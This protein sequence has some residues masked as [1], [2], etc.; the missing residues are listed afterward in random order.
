MPLLFIAKLLYKIGYIDVSE[1][2]DTSKN[3]IEGIKSKSLN[4]NELSSCLRVTN[5][6]KIGYAQSISFSEGA[7]GNAFR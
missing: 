2:L 7:R 3:P 4:E 5:F 6:V 1:N